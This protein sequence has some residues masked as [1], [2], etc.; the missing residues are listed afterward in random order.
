MLLRNTVHKPAEVQGQEGQVERIVRGKDVVQPQLDRNHHAAIQLHFEL[1]EEGDSQFDTHEN[2]HEFGLFL[3][4]TGHEINGTAEYSPQLLD[5][6]AVSEMIEHFQHVADVFITHPE[7]RLDD[8]L[9]HAA[10]CLVTLTATETP[11]TEDQ[12][13][14]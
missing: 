10:E 1:T 12:F 14:F 13:A 9:R 4:E 7:W 8:A 3:T 5:A 2:G 11:D 6:L